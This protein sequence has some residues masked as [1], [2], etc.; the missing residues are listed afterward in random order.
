MYACVLLAQQI[1]N[2]T[3]HAYVRLEF[4]KLFISY[5]QQG[6]I[7]CIDCQNKMKSET[8]LLETSPCS[9][10]SCALHR[11]MLTKCQRDQKYLE[12]SIF[13]LINRDKRLFL[14]HSTCASSVSINEWKYTRGSSFPPRLGIFFYY[15][16]R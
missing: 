16:Y 12:Y 9:P 11:K 5:I 6:C 14:L 15:S 2:K 13:L 8:I 7:N 1:T 10:Y 4:I 3:R